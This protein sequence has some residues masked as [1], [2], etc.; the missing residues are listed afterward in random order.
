MPYYYN[1]YIVLYDNIYYVDE[2]YY[3]IISLIY[4]L[5]GVDVTP[6]SHLLGSSQN[7]I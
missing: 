1:I 2:M 6:F 4:I 7:R 5:G 3:Q